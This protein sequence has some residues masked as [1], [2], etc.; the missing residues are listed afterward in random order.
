M[1]T[2]EYR[3]YCNVLLLYIYVI[4]QGK[5]SPRMIPNPDYFEDKHPYK[6]TPIVSVTAQFVLH[7]EVKRVYH[8]VYVN[9]TLELFR[10][11]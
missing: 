1:S 7:T 9:I 3:P 6:M 4:I 2:Y 10:V 5:W 8:I 11:A